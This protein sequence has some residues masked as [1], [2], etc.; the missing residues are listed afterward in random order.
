MPRKK[1]LKE[2]IGKFIEVHGDKYDYS[3][4]EYKDTH[5]KVRIICPIHGE[6]EQSPLNHSQGH[7]CPKCCKTGVRT[8]LEEF[9]TEA[10]KV[11][12][13]KYDYSKVVYINANTKV[14]IICP[15]HGEFWQRPADHL[16]G[17][18][19][20]KCGDSRKGLYQIGNTEKFIEDA[21]KVHGDKYDYSKVK[22]I[23]NRSKVYII[24]PIHGEFKQMPHLHLHGHGC[25]TCNSS[26]LEL[27]IKSLLESNNIEY[28]PQYKNKWLGKQ[29]LDFYLPKY[30]IAIEC[31]GVQHF[32]PIDYFGGK[33]AFKMTNKRDLVKNKKCKKNGI[34]I[35][36]FSNKQYE[37]NIIIDE[38]KLLEKIIKNE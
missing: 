32:K 16:N 38:N 2:V 7:G 23:N 8:T 27:Q 28:I 22:Y 18:G 30:N 4:L 36:Y 26:K 11:H 6:F 37:D 15:I 29:S 19:C 34:N 35:L 3:Q 1:T 12:G 13:N 9:I 10:K 24:C 14:C 25:P 17:V 5:T 33:E 31:Q 20:K 21:R